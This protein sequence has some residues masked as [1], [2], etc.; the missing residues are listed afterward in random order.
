MATARCRVG[1]VVGEHCTSRPPDDVNWRIAVP[2]ARSARS[3]TSE[4]ASRSGGERCRRRGE[5]T[6]SAPH[7][8][9]CQRAGPRRWRRANLGRWLAMRGC[10]CACSAVPTWARRS[11]SSR[12]PVARSR[13]AARGLALVYGG[14]NVGLMGQ[15]ADAVLAAGGEA[16]GVMPEH[17]VEREIAHPASPARVT[18]SM[19]ERKA[20][21]A[22]LASGFIALPGEFGTFEEVIEILTWNQLG[23]MSGR[24]VPRRRR[25]LHA[26]PRLLRSF[27]R[28]QLRPSTIGRWPTAV[29]VERHR[30]RH[31]PRPRHPPQVDRPRPRPHLTRIPFCLPQMSIR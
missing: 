20:L 25:F 19:H 3:T 30:P 7:R 2:T 8:P 14:G 23:L 13:A 12:S 11:P 21:M 26:A 15:L 9:K 22:E 5:F 17:L 4:A 16:V 1:H 6:G 24:R 10:G 29:T 28:G 31:V 27:R 18:T